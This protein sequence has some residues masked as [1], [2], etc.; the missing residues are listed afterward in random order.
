VSGDDVLDLVEG[1]SALVFIL[2]GGAFAF[3]GVAWVLWP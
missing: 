1:A 2:A 3:C